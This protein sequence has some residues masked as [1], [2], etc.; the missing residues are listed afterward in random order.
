[1]R[2]VPHINRKEWRMGGIWVMAVFDLLIKQLGNHHHE[3]RANIVFSYTCR[4]GMFHECTKSNG[5]L[6]Q[7]QINNKSRVDSTYNEPILEIE[8]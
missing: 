7:Q 4:S 6:Y 1:M 3:Y 5:V 8:S 2:G